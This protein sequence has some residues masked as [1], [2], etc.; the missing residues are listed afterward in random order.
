[1]LNLKVKFNKGGV[2]VNNNY[3]ENENIKYYE[4]LFNKKIIDLNDD[5]LTL[6]DMQEI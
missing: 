2:M 1:M 3:I 4:E 5:E 6:I